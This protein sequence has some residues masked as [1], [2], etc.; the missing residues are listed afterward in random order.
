MR[1]GRIERVGVVGAAVIGL[2][3]M[4]SQLSAN[5]V[6]V[7]PVGGYSLVSLVAGVYTYEI[8]FQISAGDTVQGT[9]NNGHNDQ[10]AINIP[11]NLI[12][13]NNL[14]EP[15][16]WVESTNVAGFPNL[17][18]PNGPPPFGVTVDANYVDFQ[19]SQN[20]SNAVSIGG[21]A[22]AVDLGEFI[23][24][25]N[26]AL[27]GTLN[28]G[29]TYDFNADANAFTV[30]AAVVTTPALGTVPLPSAAW[31]G[32]SSLVGMGAISLFRKRARIV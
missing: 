11:S 13:D 24:H 3:G 32:F 10:F 6:G 15:T 7:Q 1:F 30:S 29:A 21:G 19:L 25:T 22:S 31:M 8:D 16:G 9:F 5:T 18:L 28:G 2:V 26:A 20:N 23:F 12:G 27:T 14:A 17:G 4:A